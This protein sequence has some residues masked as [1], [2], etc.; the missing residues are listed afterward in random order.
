MEL[1]RLRAQDSSAP[2]TCSTC[3]SR[4]T[5]PSTLN[6]FVRYE[7]NLTRTAPSPPFATSTIIRV[8][9]LMEDGET[10]TGR[11][12]SLLYGRPRTGLRTFA[13][14]TTFIRLKIS[15]NVKVVFRGL[16]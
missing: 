4:E 2:T 7:Q 8:F 16:L 11:T 3:S 6:V 12:S 10:A 5:V 14:S 9:F 13:L 15:W 1:R